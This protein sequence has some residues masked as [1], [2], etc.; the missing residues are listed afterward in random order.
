MGSDKTEHE[1]LCVCAEQ[2]RQGRFLL[3]QKRAAQPL[4]SVIFKVRC[5]RFVSIM[6]IYPFL[7]PNATMVD[8]EILFC[9]MYPI[10]SNFP[11]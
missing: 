11:L 4:C 3:S 9:G 7:A 8:S 2:G 6:C 10:A 5:C 1:I